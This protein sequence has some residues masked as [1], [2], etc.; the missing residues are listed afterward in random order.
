MIVG[1]IG[2][3]QTI[4]SSTDGIANERP[5]LNLTWSSGNA[6]SPEVA[7]TNTNPVVDEIIWDTSTHALLPGATPS[8]TW[9]HPNSSNVDDWRIFIWEDYNDERAGWTVYDSRDSSEGWDI[10]NLTWTSPDN[11]STGESYEWFVQPITDDILGTKGQDTIFHIPAETGNTINSTDAEI[12]LQEGQ[13]VDALDYPAIFMDTYIDSGSTNS[14]Y[15]SS[16]RLLM[17]RSNYLLP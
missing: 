8:F 17:G 14:A 10:T 15:E 2:E 1:S 11:L 16:Q 12:S 9:S 5:W 4:F 13:I 7:G 3:G 6:S